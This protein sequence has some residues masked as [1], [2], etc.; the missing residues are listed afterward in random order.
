MFK[1]IYQHDTYLVNGRLRALKSLS[2]IGADNQVNTAIHCADDLTEH[3]QKSS[4]S[5]VGT[6][7]YADFCVGQCKCGVLASIAYWFI[8]F[9]QAICWLCHPLIVTA[10][11]NAN[12]TEC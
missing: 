7:C 9:Y 10:K 12:Q 3:C 11:L 1:I 6:C 2:K 5:V 4:A 8:I